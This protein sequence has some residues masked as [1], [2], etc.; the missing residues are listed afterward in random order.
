MK[1]QLQ[2]RIGIPAE[3]GGRV[4]WGCWKE[5]AEPTQ[6]EPLSPTL[7]LEFLEAEVPDVPDSTPLTFVPNTHSALGFDFKQ[8]AD[9]LSE[10]RMRSTKQPDGRTTPTRRSPER[11]SVDESPEKK[12]RREDESRTRMSDVSS[13]HSNIS[14]EATVSAVDL[15]EQMRIMFRE[16]VGGIRNDVQKVQGCVDLLA[17]RVDAVDANARKANADFERKLALA[18]KERMESTNQILERLDKLD[19]QT[20]HGAEELR[21][22]SQEARRATEAAGA[23]ATVNV[24]NA[25]C[26]SF[27]VDEPVAI[28]GGF[29]WDSNKERTVP[30]A[31][32]YRAR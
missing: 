4:L 28:L 13:R 30:F 24:A 23:R 1:H 14:T 25:H 7:S 10:K 27:A 3:V 16:E 5:T 31:K 29:R 20:K 9:R 2:H 22:A 19:Q 21:K 32:K 8:A 18:T 12:R 17:N 11:H 26:A 15:V 6:I